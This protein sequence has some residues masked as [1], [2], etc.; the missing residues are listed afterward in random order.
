[1]DA[2]A[3]LR[4]A[5]SGLTGVLP[6][7]VVVLPNGAIDDRRDHPALPEVVAVSLA[8]EV[9]RRA[10]DEPVYA[11][12]TSHLLRQCL[13]T[14]DPGAWRA[15][16]DD[17]ATGDLD[18]AAAAAFWGE[19]DAMG[20]AVQ[21]LVECTTG[22]H[23][24]VVVR[25]LHRALTLVGPPAPQRTGVA[26]QAAFPRLMRTLS[27]RAADVSVDKRAATITAL[28]RLMVWCDI[29]HDALASMLGTALRDGP[30]DVLRL[31]LS[32]P[33]AALAAHD[34][35]L[36]ERVLQRAERASQANRYPACTLL[37]VMAPDQLRPFGDR[38]RRLVQRALD[39]AAAQ[40]SVDTGLALACGVLARAVAAPR[41]L[42]FTLAHAL[43]CMSAGA[44][45]GDG[46]P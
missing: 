30:D 11:R 21:C 10:A 43:C 32:A 3:D 44:R 17:A 41:S 8:C 25:S 5:L 7:R 45:R 39:T 16:M 24:W 34:P 15:F 13:D 42:D 14:N 18:V 36:V 38:V 37:A 28:G 19:P 26:L 2:A 9:L 22:M 40:G 29:P 35:A 1:M 33:V 23:A 6:R 27:K 20:R 4:A 12:H 31:F 46:P